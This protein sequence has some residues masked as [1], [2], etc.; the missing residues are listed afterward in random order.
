MK[1]IDGSS[2]ATTRGTIEPSFAPA[3]FSFCFRGIE[4][5]T[6]R[7][8]KTFEQNKYENQN[9][10]LNQFQRENYISTIAH[11]IRGVHKN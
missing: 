2:D 4:D 9:I 1:I 5:S 8:S 6:K 11:I 3:L 10:Y 7:T